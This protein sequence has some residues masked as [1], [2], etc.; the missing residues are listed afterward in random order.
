MLL[1]P[2][3]IVGSEHQVFKTGEFPGETPPQP[4]QKAGKRLTFSLWGL[5]GPRAV[6]VGRRGSPGRKN[7]W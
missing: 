2:G 3:G 6:C 7:T 1:V 4:M 5:L